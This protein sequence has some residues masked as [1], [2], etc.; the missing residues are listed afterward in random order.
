MTTASFLSTSAGIPC[1]WRCQF[2]LNLTICTRVAC[3]KKKAHR[4]A[5][6]RWNSTTAV[7]SFLTILWTG[8]WL[9]HSPHQWTFW[10]KLAL[11][12]AGFVRVVACKQQ[13]SYQQAENPK[14]GGDAKGDGKWFSNLCTFF[15]L[16]FWCCLHKSSR[17][18][19]DFS[20]RWRC[21]METRLVLL[22]R[23]RG[24]VPE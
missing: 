3:L 20:G 5:N 18:C 9:P 12:G 7:T 19:S 15:L 6:K 23:G 17:V 4:L 8:S 10:L 11:E 22:L 13:W 16:L 21:R 24:N 1:S 2:I 14:T